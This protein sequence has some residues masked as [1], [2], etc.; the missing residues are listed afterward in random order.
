[1][2]G[3]G[4]KLQFDGCADAGAPDILDFI[5]I[6]GGNAQ[7]PASRISGCESAGIGKCPV[8]AKRQFRR[9]PVL[10]TCPDPADGAE[11]AVICDIG[12]ENP[13]CLIRFDDC[14]RIALSEPVDDPVRLRSSGYQVVN[15]PGGNIW[16]SRA[17]MPFRRRLPGTGGTGCCFR[18]GYGQ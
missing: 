2:R 8:E 4:S 14:G 6:N 18:Y 15:E 9:D 13:A 5:R 17:F 7:I 12:Q 1:M 16:E 3:F 10:K 11:F